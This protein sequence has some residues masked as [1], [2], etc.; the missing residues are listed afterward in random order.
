MWKLAR[1]SDG[2]DNEGGFLGSST[3]KTYGQLLSTQRRAFQESVVLAEK[4]HG[5]GKWGEM[6]SEIWSRRGAESWGE[7]VRLSRCEQGL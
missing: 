7:Q 6:R 5:M 4:G 3:T 1:E 2:G